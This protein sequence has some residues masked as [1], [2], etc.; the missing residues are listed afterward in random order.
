[1]RSATVTAR[2]TVSK[3]KPAAL[4]TS[5]LFLVSYLAYHFQAGSVKYA[6]QG[7]MRTAYFAILLSHTVLAALVAPLAIVTVVRAWK[8]KFDRHVAIARWTL[9]VWMYVSLTGILVYL[10][11]YQIP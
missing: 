1:M 10:M 2:L 5:T 9:P 3:P 11:L 4:V 8:E 6:G 7:F